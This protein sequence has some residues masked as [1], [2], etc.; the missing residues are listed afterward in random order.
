MIYPTAAKLIAAVILGIIGFVL[1][2]LV[3]PLLQ[4]GTNVGW[5]PLVNMVIG[6][7]AGWI[8]VGR[9]AGRG[10]SG[11]IGN[12]LTGGAVLLFWGLFVQSF[13][14]MLRLSLRNRYDGPV[15]ALTDMLETGYEW[16]L[17]A[18]T[19]PLFSLTLLLGAVAAGLSAEIAARLW[20]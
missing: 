20:R 7:L 10:T 15:Q 9:R 14:E 1:S 19:S 4:E 5:F 6:L 8:T 13:N 12:G 17:L 16:G 11:A 2:L 18:L 3:V